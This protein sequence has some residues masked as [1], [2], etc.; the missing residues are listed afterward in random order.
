MFSEE[1]QVEVGLVH[2]VDPRELDQFE[3]NWDYLTLQDPPTTP[4]AESAP[5]EATG[6]YRGIVPAKTIER[7][8]IALNGAIVG[9]FCI[10]FPIEVTL[11]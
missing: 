9:P 2:Q 7:R 11:V 3:G 8:D 5:F 10:S 4:Q 6:L 1:T